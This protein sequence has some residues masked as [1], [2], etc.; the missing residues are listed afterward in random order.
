MSTWDDERRPNR[1]GWSDPNPP[2][3]WASH[4][5]QPSLSETHGSGTHGWL[6][7]PPVA[8]SLWPII[9]QEKRT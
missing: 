4:S 2:S 1:S 6:I 5:G 3:G 9:Q 8:W 7:V